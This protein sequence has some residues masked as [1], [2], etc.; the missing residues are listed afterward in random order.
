[1]ALYF[2]DFINHAA[3]QRDDTGTECASIDDV[4]RAARETLPH[5][6]KDEIPTDG[7]RR[8]FTVVARDE[9]GRAVY[10]ATLAFAG[11][12]LDERP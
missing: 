10:T 1:M 4:R 8:F 5:I 2:F 12:R 7:D 3:T 11:M 9:S 6:A